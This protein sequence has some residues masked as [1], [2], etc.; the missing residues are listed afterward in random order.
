MICGRGYSL[1]A[2]EGPAFLSGLLRP[3]RDSE[4][5]SGLGV[6]AGCHFTL[7]PRMRGGAVGTPGGVYINEQGHEEC[8][9]NAD[10]T[11]KDAKDIDFGPDPGDEPTAGPSVSE[12]PRRALGDRTRYNKAIN[13]LKGSGG[14]NVKADD[15]TIPRKRKASSGDGK[16]K[17]RATEESEGERG[18]DSYSGEDEDSRGSDSDDD[19]DREAIVTN[20]ELADS[21][22]HRTVP[23]GAVRRPKAPK[24]RRK[25]AKQ[26]PAEAPDIP[27]AQVRAPERETKTPTTSS[28][29]RHFFKDISP[30]RVKGQAAEA[31]VF[32][33]N[34]CPVGS[35]HNRVEISPKQK[36]S[37][38]NLT[39]HLKKCS[40]VIHQFWE[41][42]QTRKTALSAE[43]V[44][45]ASGSKVLTAAELKHL[46]G[47]SGAPIVQQQTLIAALERAEQLKRG[48]W[49]QKTFQRLL[50]EWLVV[51]DQPFIEV[52]RAEFKALLNYVWFR[53]TPLSIPSATTARRDI[54][55]M[56]QEL[57]AH[58]VEFFRK[59]PGKRN[60][61][62]TF[63]NLS[64]SIRARTWPKLC[65]SA[66]YDTVLRS[67]LWRS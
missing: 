3:L 13:E 34:H 15:S 36:S 29:I 41:H 52:E 20:E 31:Q 40:P 65:G 46:I 22:V 54:I 2:V 42:I 44:T 27:S 49:D 14:K 39:N 64:A 63:A 18:D 37:Y 33:C 47:S 10:G 6:K 4:T 35:E 53:S 1:G 55:K 24:R 43:E 12:R 17:G 9:R 16:G 7:L 38:N 32:L 30:Q 61:S 8:A 19:S 51:C 21:L 66:L 62:S 59:L 45:I 5:M 56:G 67:A 50:Y 26:S 60:S 48:E 25:K 11:Y 58:L 23:E 28:L 57:E